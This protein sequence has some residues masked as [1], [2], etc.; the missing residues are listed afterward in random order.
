M[1]FREKYFCSLNDLL[2]ILGK[3]VFGWR[4]LRH[5]YH[6]YS[7]DKIGCGHDFIMVR[8]NACYLSFMSTNI[9]NNSSGGIVACS[10]IIRISLACCV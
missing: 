2:F 8:E 5:S 7:K 1:P 9:K 10:S 4:M 3:H 6:Q